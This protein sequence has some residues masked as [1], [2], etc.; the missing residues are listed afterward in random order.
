M[1]D[2]ASSG[3]SLFASPLASA[4]TQNKVLDVANWFAATKAGGEGAGRRPQPFNCAFVSIKNGT[5]DYLR[6]GDVVEFTDFALSDSLDADYLWFHGGIPDL[7]H[8]GWGI[9]RQLTAPNEFEDAHVV[10]P[11]V[12]FVNVTNAN[13]KYAVLKSGQ[14][15]LQS[16]A[17]GPVR[18]LYKPTGTGELSCAVLIGFPG[19]AVYIGKTDAA[20]NKGSSGIVS[21]Y[22]GGTE[23]DT[24]LN[25][26]VR[27]RFANVAI[28]KWVA[29]I[30]IDG[31]FYMIAAEC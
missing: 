25:E 19:S 7:T 24:T 5:G 11:C 12:A 1:P 26:T 10:G 13:H 31:T 20:I 9:V 28:N 16:A 17:S 3:T 4:R 8:V 29:Y 27:N 22:E 18:I 14:K 30:D 23:A 2:R 21:R 15:V 6:G